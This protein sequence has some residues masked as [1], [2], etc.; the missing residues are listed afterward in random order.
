[1]LAFYSDG[2]PLEKE[3]FRFDDIRF[4]IGEETD[5]S[6]PLVE[7]R[8]KFPALFKSVLRNRPEPFADNPFGKA[9][10]YTRYS[11]RDP[12][13][14]EQETWADTIARGVEGCL[15]IRQDWYQKNGITF[16]EDYWQ[17]VAIDMA[18]ASYDLKMTFPG[19]GLWAG[20]TE[21]VY[22]RGSMALNNCGFSAINN[23]SNDVAWCMNALMCGVGVGFSANPWNGVLRRPHRDYKL[24]YVIPDDREGWVNSIRLLIESYEDGGREVIFDYSKLRAKGEPIR[25]FGGV[26]SGYVPLY[27]L[28][29]R[30]RSYLDRYLAGIFSR[31]RLVNDIIN[32]VGVCVIAGNVRRSA[33]IS[34]GRASD[35][36]FLKLKDFSKYDG[37]GNKIYA[38]SGDDRADIGWT[39]NNSVSLESHEDFL[40]LPRIAEY[41]LNNG[42][43]GLFNL[44]NIR[45]FGRLFE[46]NPDN[47]IGSNPCGEIPL[48]DKELC[49][50]S[51]TFP[52]R[53]AVSAKDY[54]AVNRLAAI[55]AST[56]SL[57]PTKDKETNDIIE[58]NRRIGVSQTG[59]ADWLENFP[60]SVA[61]R[62]MRDAYKVIKET[63]VHLAQ[64]AGVKPAIRLTTVKPSGTVSQLAGVSS[65]MHWPTFP[66]AI[67][68]IR[69][70][71]DSP[72]TELLI[73]AGIPHEEDVVSPNTIVFEFPID[74]SQSRPATRVSIWQ[75]AAR[76]A[77]LQREWAD[78]MVSNTIYFSPGEA[79][80]LEHVIAE[81]APITK[82]MSFLPHT[83]KGAYAQ[84]PYEG[85]SKSEY[86]KRR[87]AITNVD[88]SVFSGSDGVEDKFCS[89][90][91]CS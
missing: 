2:A 18:I 73:Q 69:Q 34:L 61:T 84:M 79:K 44:V 29:N 33:E 12:D 25:G 19:R 67:R 21:Y 10:Y 45:K 52:S 89:N 3:N 41:I 35:E 78:N 30:V 37:F 1:M 38:G 76:V 86:N 6:Q 13:T 56:I 39:S 40:Q 31:T 9:V 8:W 17:G 57:L 60:S 42:E 87:R 72:A 36:D 46:P 16:D 90:D 58:E 27:D 81:F 71:V 80:E 32:A 83:K 11:R 77:M 59:I 22:H 91:S 47:A 53:M 49:N 4:L 14:G 50:L 48:A 68:R 64:E 63:N 54:L 24:L 75:Q 62:W 51:E 23:L 7:A 28:H 82:T 66:Y 26:S 85:I 74:Q 20:G 88:W 15:S 5:H 55:Y 43:P 70:G 65:G